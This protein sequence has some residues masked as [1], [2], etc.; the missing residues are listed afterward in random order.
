M[1]A[2]QPWPGP[3]S[4]GVDARV[5]IGS[6]PVE[7]DEDLG[8]PA[9]HS[10]DLRPRQAPGKSVKVVSRPQ[11][12]RT[13]DRERAHRAM[14]PATRRAGADRGTV[15]GPRTSLVPMRPRAVYT[16]EPTMLLAVEVPDSA[17]AGHDEEIG[18][19][20]DIREHVAAR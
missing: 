19:I 3:C 15:A 20:G 13:P 7:L 14:D 17:I 18:G 1:D 10:E 5:V 16:E 9:V 2:H 11:G 12:V 6:R 8:C 4:V